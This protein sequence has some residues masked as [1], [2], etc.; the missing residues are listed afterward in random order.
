MNYLHLEAQSH[1]GEGL[2]YL[3]KVLKDVLDGCVQ[4][5]V[6]KVILEH[7]QQF[8]TLAELLKSQEKSLNRKQLE[9]VVKWRKEEWQEYDELKTLLLNLVQ[10][11]HALKPGNLLVL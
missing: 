7:E 3:D 11:C 1:I 8:I 10:Q 9:T 6:L 4:V 2:S 5:N